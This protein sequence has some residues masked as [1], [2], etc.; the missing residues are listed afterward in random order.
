MGKDTG[1]A[2]GSAMEV[3]L[4]LEQLI[5]RGARALIQNAIEVEVREL[6]ADYGDV[7]T[8]SGVAAVVRNGYLPARR[9]SPQR[10]RSRCAF[11]RCAT[12]RGP[13]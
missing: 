8:L 12:A 11:P 13:G 10:V 6:L 5:Q 7:R 9:F 3:G 1:K 4:T 2:S